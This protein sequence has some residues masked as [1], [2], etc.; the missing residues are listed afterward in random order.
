[1]V[2]Y[3][4]ARLLRWLVAAGA[5]GLFLAGLFLHGAVAGVLLL[6]VAAIL[7]TLTSRTW[8]G[9]HPRGRAARLVVLAMVLVV[10]ATKFAS[11]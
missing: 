8:A 10:A 3:Q 7:I 9:L 6:L 2:T 11:G 1:M 5:G 4:V